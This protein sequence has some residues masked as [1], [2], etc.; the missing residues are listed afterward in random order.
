MFTYKGQSDFVKHSVVGTNVDE[1]SWARRK[2]DKGEISNEERKHFVI[3]QI[4][5]KQ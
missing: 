5:T 1:H 3:A 2:E 4:Y